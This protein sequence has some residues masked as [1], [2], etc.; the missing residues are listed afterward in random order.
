MSITTE[1][2][3]LTNAK[4]AIVAAIE[5]KGVTVPDTTMLDGMAALIE[6]IEAGGN[7]FGVTCTYGTFTPSEKLTPE[8]NPITITHGLGQTLYTFLIFRTT[9][10]PADIW[11]EI[12]FIGLIGS[13][14][15]P[16]ITAYGCYSS[17]STS[18]GFNYTCKMVKQSAD[19]EQITFKTDKYG[20]LN[21]GTTYIWF[22]FG[23]E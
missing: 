19:A 15:S 1:L 13:G 18:N 11:G 17:A 22:A 16:L 6:S 5:G 4:A 14:I 12:G 23:L 10:R 3:R 20:Y 8:S 7:P 9:S 2:T 21:G